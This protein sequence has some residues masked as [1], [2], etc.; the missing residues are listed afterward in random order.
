MRGRHRDDSAAETRDPEQLIVD[1]VHPPLPVLTKALTQ[2]A[3]GAPQS[4]YNGGLNQGTVRYFDVTPDDRNPAPLRSEPGR[5]GLPNDV[6]SL[7]YE[8]ST[9]RVGLQ[10]VNLDRDKPKSLI[11]QAGMF[12]QHTFTTCESDRGEEV[13]VNGKHVQ[14]TLRP[15][16]KVRLTLGLQRFV[17][18][19]TYTFPWHGDAIPVP[20][21]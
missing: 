5:P 10:L 12:A 9:D 7:V 2:V 21:Q 19:P 3:L 20:F 18:T 4:V 13:Y 11:V 15:A 6:A 14:M 8:L 1:N 17:N 16:S